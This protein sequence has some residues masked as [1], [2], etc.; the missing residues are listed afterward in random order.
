MERLTKGGGSGK[1]PSPSMLRENPFFSSSED[2]CDSLSFIT[3]IHP[4][5]PGVH[6]LKVKNIVIV[7]LGV[8][9]RVE[10]YNSLGELCGYLTR[11]CEVST[12]I[13]C[14]KK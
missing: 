14:M 10:I 12:L 8:G 9:N 1:A 6:S 2:S 5:E 13:A 7:S 3:E 4:H 11:K